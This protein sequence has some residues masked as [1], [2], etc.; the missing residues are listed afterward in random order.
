MEMIGLA[1]PDAP[2]AHGVP[3]E[4]VVAH[5]RAGDIAQFEILMRRYNQRL[6]RVV[7]SIL[8]DDAEAEDVVQDAYVRA[9]TYLD[10]YAGE[11]KFSTW[12]TRIAVNEALRR[13]R[14]RRRSTNIE[15]LAPLE[16]GEGEGPEQ[17]VFH[18][19]LRSAMHTAV[20]RLPER[21]R[22][23]FMLRDVDGLSTGETARCLDIPAQT[24]KT[25]LHRGRALLRKELGGAVGGAV[26]DLFA[27][28]FAR[29]DRMVVQVLRRIG[30]VPRK[31]LRGDV[32]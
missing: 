7:R 26:Q 31:R 3:D 6:Y 14:V 32:K 24:V 29:C 2:P 28:G 19:E 15:T 10:Q 1:Q 18:R 30:A 21:Y 27:F 12:L 13:V 20:D 16:A 25:R 5:V 17:Q 22:S 9:Y 4:A 23:V 11:A 8:R